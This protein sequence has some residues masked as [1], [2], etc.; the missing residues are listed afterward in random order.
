MTTIQALRGT[1][2]DS[3]KTPS[4]GFL[5]NPRKILRIY[6]EVLEAFNS[7]GTD[8]LVIGYA[9]DTDA[10]ATS[11]DVSTTGVKVVTL[12]TGVSYDATPRE[13]RATYAAGGTDPTAGAAVILIEYADLPRQP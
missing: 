4:L 10:Y 11:I 3:N 13:V 12:G 5:R 1:I 6:V 9:T 7:D 2:S 8:T